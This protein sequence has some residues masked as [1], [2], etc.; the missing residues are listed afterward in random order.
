MARPKKYSTAEER[1]QAKRESNN[2]SYSKN[3]DKTSHRRKEKY[4]NNKHRQRHTRVSP[5]KTARA[6][7]PVKE[8]LS[9][10]TPATQPAQRVLT[11]LRG[12]SSVVEQRFTALLLKRSVKDF[13]RDLL[14]DYCTG[15]D[16]QM[17]HAELFSA[18]LD[19]VNALQET[20]A[21]VMAEFL[22]ADGCSDAYRDL[23]QLD[24]RIDSLVKALEDMFCYALEG[25]AALVQAYNRRTLYWQ[26]L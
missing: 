5:I 14:R 4:R 7:Q 24:N 19:R 26:S 16:S 6:P 9:S 1:R 15:S 2:R 10:E 8:V 12:C 25:P 18:P 13:A 11:T 17:G 21:E 3:R 20:H 23:E 22:Q